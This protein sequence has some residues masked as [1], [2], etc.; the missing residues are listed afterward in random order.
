MKISRGGDYV[1][2]AVTTGRP[3][4]PHGAYMLS[5]PVTSIIFL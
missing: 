2:G 3:A 4:A 1:R 5:Y